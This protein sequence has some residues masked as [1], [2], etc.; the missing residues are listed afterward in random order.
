M[1]KRILS[2]KSIYYADNTKT[3]LVGRRV[4]G[5]REVSCREVSCREVSVDG[6]AVNI[7]YIYLDAV[8]TSLDVFSLSLV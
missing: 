1:Y 2:N 3:R 6:L 8:R 5:H 7:V 4:V